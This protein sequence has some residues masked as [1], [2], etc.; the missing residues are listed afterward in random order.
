MQ[1][2]QKTSE[3]YRSDDRAEPEGPNGA[4]SISFTEP[5]GKEAL[6]DGLIET[7]ISEKNLADAFRQVVA[8]H[9]AP[10]SDGMTVEQVPE[11][12]EKNRA[13]LID[14]IRNGTYK[15]LQYEAS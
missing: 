11:W 15:P 7:V 4:D 2:K 3:S 14:K 6:Y 9:G 8:N 1:R 13:V 10:G 5:D 12:F